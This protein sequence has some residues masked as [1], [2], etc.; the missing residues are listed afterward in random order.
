[1]HDVRDPVPFFWSDSSG[2]GQRVAN[3]A[4]VFSAQLEL[5]IQSATLFYQYRNLTG[6]AYEQIPGLTMPPNDTLTE[7]LTVPVPPN[8]AESATVTALLDA[9][10]PF[11]SSVP[12]L[13]VV[14]PE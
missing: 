9:S 14:L 7:P 12:A 4:Q 3:D 13:I 6:R 8:V 5:R 11:T 2:T 1:M 10:D